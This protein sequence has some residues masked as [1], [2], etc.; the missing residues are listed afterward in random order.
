MA[1]H[2]VG[3]GV[4]RQAQSNTLSISS[5]VHQASMTFWMSCEGT[6][7]VVSSDDAVFIQGAL[8]EVELALS[9]SAVIV[10]VVLFL[11][12]RDWR[13]T[14]IPA[15]TMPVA[16]IGTLAAIYMVGFSINIL[17]ILAIVLAT[18]LV[19]D[20]A[21]VVLENIVR[22]R[23][24]G[25]GPRAAAV[26]GDA[27]GVFRRACDDRDACRGFRTALVP[28][29]PAWWSLPRIRFSVGICSS[30]VFGDGADA[31]P[32][33]G[34]AHAAGGETRRH[35]ILAASERASRP[36]TAQPRR[37]PAQP[38]YRRCGR[39][40]VLRRRLCHLHHDPRRN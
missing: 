26:L 11:F 8:H 38:D 39:R 7:I 2:G 25:M 34:L 12:L 35:G 22:R 15:L 21:I 19:V 20:D 9:L 10:L 1:L 33:D 28:A 14:L 29:G 27:G 5:G 37:L 6:K 18:G 13:A 3:L 40:A 24:E 36:S 4:I 32:D 17:T 30:L 23:S 31:L 16:L